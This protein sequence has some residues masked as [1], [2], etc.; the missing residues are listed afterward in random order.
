MA[1]KLNIALGSQVFT[2]A[3]ARWD[4]LLASDEGQLVLDKLADEA[5]AEIRAGHAE[6]TI[7][8]KV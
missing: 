1:E 4:E 8:A 6:P 5:L 2:E 7:L 3:N